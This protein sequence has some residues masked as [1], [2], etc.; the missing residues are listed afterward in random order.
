MEADVLDEVIAVDARAFPFPVAINACQGRCEHGNEEGREMVIRCA[1]P[2]EHDKVEQEGVLGIKILCY[3]MEECD[4]RVMIGKGKK[5][6]ALCPQVTKEPSE[7]LRGQ[8]LA[9]SGKRK[10]HAYA[11]AWA[12]R[13]SEPATLVK[14]YS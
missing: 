10:A 2:V 13:A 7:S 3:V 14:I 4:Q 1:L 9:D 8:L 6:R 12:S 11:A 5:R